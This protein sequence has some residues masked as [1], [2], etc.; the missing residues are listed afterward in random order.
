MNDNSNPIE[1][2][3]PAG[4]HND[5]PQISGQTSPAPN[6][7]LFTPPAP[8]TPGSFHPG[9]WTL[10]PEESPGEPQ[11]LPNNSPLDY[12]AATG[13]QYSSP[14]SATSGTNS[15]NATNSANSTGFDPYGLNY[16]QIQPGIIPLRPL[17][18]GDIYNGAFCAI[19]QA[20]SVMFGLVLAL[21]AGLGGLMGA[22]LYFL[23]PDLNTYLADDFDADGTEAAL[24]SLWKITESTMLAGVITG[25]LQ[26]FIVSLTLAICVAGLGPLVLGRR[27]TVADVW[28]TLK[29]HL[30]GIIGYS[31]LLIVGSALL[32]GLGLLPLGG[33]F[34]INIE[35]F[36]ASLGLLG[37]T[38]LTLMVVGVFSTWI[39]V[40]LV[41]A[42]PTAIMEDISIISALKRSW[43]L[44]K[45]SFWKFFGI[46]LLTTLIVSF[47]G[48]G[49]NTVIG[50]ILSAV[51]LVNQN[52]TIIM[53]LS[54]VLSSVITGL[55]MPFYGAVLGL[56]YIDTRIRREG[57]AVR[58]LQATQRG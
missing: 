46:I 21:W 58:L 43:R 23:I 18:L 12:P 39:S 10:T 45:G 31:L 47:L 16:Q 56:L 25:L 19:R 52:F 37:L 51:V 27:P 44:T 9:S 28:Q 50:F 55:T 1:T 53:T 24:E 17:S 54:A 2:T 4:S 34:L 49:L 36:G 57:L 38:F 14:S 6:E 29:S 11:P 3:P 48:Q 13:S 41:F 7:P 35:D 22:L 30:W 32:L 5:T 33:F 8:S 20:P 40:K 42:I 15:F 26:L